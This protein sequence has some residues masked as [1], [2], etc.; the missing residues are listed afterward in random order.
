MANARVVVA[1][2]VIVAVAIV[3]VLGQVQ[4]AVP[5]P[6]DSSASFPVWARG[7]RRRPAVAGVRQKGEAEARQPLLPD[8]LASDCDCLQG[9]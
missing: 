7:P 3:V 8:Q 2:V 4:V 1:A 5:A 9:P 6:H